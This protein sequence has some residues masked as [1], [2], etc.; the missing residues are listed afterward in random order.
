MSAKEINGKVESPERKPYFCPHH[1]M[2]AAILSSDQLGGPPKEDKRALY[3][4]DLAQE[5]L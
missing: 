1:G 4:S 3:A 5:K 2:L